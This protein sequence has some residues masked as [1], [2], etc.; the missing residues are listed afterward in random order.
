MKG[1][2]AKLGTIRG[3]RAHAAAVKKASVLKRDE[4]IKWGPEDVKETETTEGLVTTHHKDMSQKG[5]SRGYTPHEDYDPKKGCEEWLRKPGNEGKTCADYEA[6]SK[7]WI[8]EKQKEHQ[9]GGS[10]TK[11]SCPDPALSLI[12]I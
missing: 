10:E 4:E 5:I 8:E 6:A 2:P 12:H 3:T 1:S 7:K 11:C 9:R